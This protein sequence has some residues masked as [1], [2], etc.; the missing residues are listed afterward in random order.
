MAKITGVAT[1]WKGKVG[2][3]VFAMWKGI[4]VVK[5][6]VIP[7][8]PRTPA[9]TTNRDLFTLF[10]FMF[11]ALVTPLVHKFWDPFVTQHQTG[12]GN[13]LGANQGA[14]SGGVLDFEDTVITKGSLPGEDILSATYDAATGA[15]LCTW[16]ETLPEGA[17]TT[18]FACC[19]V[20][21]KV[22][23]K[24]NFSD[25]SAVRGDETVGTF[26]NDGLAPGDVFIYLFFFTGDFAAPDI[27]SVSNNVGQVSVAA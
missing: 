11:K 3:Y 9:Q 8:N 7:H 6:R 16:D 14:Q 15:V 4:Q 27:I 19:A 22:N 24:W 13:L 18:D 12:W 5:T 25:G 17:R 23:N 1:G 21:D 2:N 26:A 10:I 20:Y